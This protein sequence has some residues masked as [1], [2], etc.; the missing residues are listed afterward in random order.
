MSEVQEICRLLDERGIKYELDVFSSGH[1]ATFSINYCDDCSD[2]LTHIYV[3]G[4]CISVERSYLTLKM[5]VDAILG[6]TCEMHPCEDDLFVGLTTLRCS[7]CGWT[8]FHE[9]QID[10]DAGDFFAFPYPRFCPHCGR[11]VVQS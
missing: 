10:K 2:Y 4:S 3:I 8:M 11:K 1:R 5:A 7:E 6:E 9:Y